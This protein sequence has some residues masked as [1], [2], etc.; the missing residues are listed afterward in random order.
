[1]AE[2][3]KKEP[4]SN[5]QAGPQ[6]TAPATTAPA[7][8]ADSTDEELLSVRDQ[9]QKK[10][11]EK[12]GDKKMYSEGDVAELLRKM[13]KKFSQNKESADEEFIDLLDPNAVKR[14]F[15]R[16]ARMNNK[17]VIGLKDTNTDSYSDQPI[18]VSNVENPLKKG[19]YIPWTT[20]MYDDGTEELYPY[21]SFMNRSIGV[22]GE[23]IDEKKQD[24]SEKFGLIDVKVVDQD[25]WNMK[26][27]GKK[28]LAKA[29]KF[30]TV[31]VCKEIKGGKTLSVTED[32]INKAEAPYSELRKFLEETK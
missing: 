8:S 24:V 29:L 19:E 16:L 31:Y 7:D 3:E 13:E 21:L 9:V 20:L 25:E 12:A 26:D 18:Y 28:V 11:E 1:M 5:T 10:I 23:V 15:V 22:W 30:R 32:V 17:F 4:S 27:T 14:K 6:T 2:E